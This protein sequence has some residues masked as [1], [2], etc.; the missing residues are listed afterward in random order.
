MD[1][2]TSSGSFETAA[3]N[4]SYSSHSLAPS[5]SNELL[6]HSKSNLDLLEGEKELK[7]I[8][9]HKRVVSNPFDVIYNSPDK[10]RLSNNT[11]DTKRF[12]G[13]SFKT[14][15]IPFNPHVPFTPSTPHNLYNKDNRVVSD[16][17]PTVTRIDQE[18]VSRSG[19]V[20]SRTAS[21]R[22]RYKLIQR[23]KMVNKKSLDIHS[24][25]FDTESNFGSNYGSTYGSKAQPD[26][27]DKYKYPKLRFLFPVKRKT[28]L[29]KNPA[30]RLLREARE[31]RSKF[32]TED[33]LQEFLVMSNAEKIMK[34]L[35]PP[36]MKLYDYSN[37][38]TRKP[39]LKKTSRVF[40]INDNNNFQIINPTI[41]KKTISGPFI[42]TLTKNGYN[43]FPQNDRKEFNLLDSIYNRYRQKAFSSNLKIP[44]KFTDYF[45]DEL[46]SDLVSPF[47]IDNF[48]KKLLFEILLRRTLA[49][50][51][52]YR[53]KQNGYTGKRTN[54]D[55]EDDS[56]SSSS[57]SSGNPDIRHSH[58]PELV[59][60]DSDSEND[61]DSINTDDLMQ[62]NASL[63]SGLLPSPQISYKSDM[64][65][66][67]E[68]KPEF[69]K[70]S[71]GGDLDSRYFK[72]ENKSR[73]TASTNDL[74]N[75]VKHVTPRTPAEPVFPSSPGRG[76]RRDDK[77]QKRD[78][79][80]AML[81]QYTSFEL[82]PINRSVETFSSSSGSERLSRT[83]PLELS[84]NHSLRSN[85]SRNQSLKSNTSTLL[86]H[87]RSATVGSSSSINLLALGVHTENK[88]NSNATSGSGSIDFDKT[89]RQSHS[90]SG[91]SILQDL[92]DLSSQLS[93]FIRDPKEPKFVHKNIITEDD[94]LFQQPMDINL[95]NQN[96]LET[97]KLSSS[98][99]EKLNAEKLIAKKTIK[100]VYHP[101]IKSMQGSISE[102]SHQSYYKPVNKNLEAIN[103]SESSPPE[104]VLV[105]DD[106]I[107]TTS[108][109][110]PYFY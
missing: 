17:P 50:K 58:I 86:N 56:S 63:F 16:L 61:N 109:A 77:H 96:V 80:L 106:S 49:A 33:E 85:L 54:R 76:F 52:D 45:P 84:R 26:H 14:P 73:R 24:P 79:E 65:G 75:L 66:D 25:S 27:K 43:P 21:L 13:I 3:L 70:E 95:S 64:F 104:N 82:K 46:D 92:E 107:S 35:I 62:Q 57:D 8:F 40:Q 74:L 98:S 38:I 10:K 44:L 34:E 53:L 1:I 47:D 110:K 18:G 30:Y 42:D 28:S 39:L 71:E 89:H 7:P 15:T 81:Q 72:S 5:K 29:K 93:T 11:A 105:R 103:E 20:I 19:S 6:L 36:T 90:T 83:P 9:Q 32:K 67:F 55:K 12:S 101:D 69:F 37:I 99:L 2:R 68:F 94:P 100:P 23:N 97:V 41:E 4:L 60:T 31:R 87:K 22:N 91:T 51:I 78:D 48:N 108:I 102:T 59:N 88:R